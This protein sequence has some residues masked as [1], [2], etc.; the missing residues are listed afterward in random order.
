MTSTFFWDFLNNSGEMF[1]EA[2]I[3]VKLDNGHISAFLQHSLKDLSSDTT[4]ASYIYLS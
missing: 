4:I 3:E 1:L 2:K